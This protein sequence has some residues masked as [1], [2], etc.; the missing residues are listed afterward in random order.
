MRTVPETIAYLRAMVANENVN[1]ML[2]EAAEM[3]PLLAWKASCASREAMSHHNLFVSARKVP[4]Q[5]PI[6]EMTALLDHVR[7]LEDDLECAL[8]DDRGVL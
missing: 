1:L 8:N 5:I 6:D 3:T 7:Q 4:M 2:I